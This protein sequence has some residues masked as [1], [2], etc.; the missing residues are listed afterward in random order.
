[1]CGTASGVL[2]TNGARTQAARA[3]CA[4]SCAKLTGGLDVGECGRTGVSLYS[5]I[6]A[7]QSQLRVLSH[8]HPLDLL[9]ADVRACPAGSSVALS[10]P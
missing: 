5:V 3:A 2:A 4:Q 6:A 1:V 9:R 7:Q 10:T 8:T